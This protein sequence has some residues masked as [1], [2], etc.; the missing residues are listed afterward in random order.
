M[1]ISLVG[2]ARK[3][4][5]RP[6]Q[7]DGEARSAVPGLLGFLTSLNEPVFEFDET[8]QCHYM[9][10]AFR[11]LVGL[12]AD[13]SEDPQLTIRRDNV[14]PWWLRE[15]EYA[16]WNFFVEVHRSGRS[17]ELGIRPKVFSLKHVDGSDVPCELIG[18]RLLSRTG[19]LLGLV[20][21]VT[22]L[23]VPSNRNPD[24]SQVTSEL[25]RLSSAVKQLVAGGDTAVSVPPRPFPFVERRAPVVK[26]VPETGTRDLALVPDADSSTSSRLESLSDRE[27]DILRGLLEGKR[28]ATMARE[29]FLSEHTIR[30]H[31]K[32]IYRKVG[33]HSLGELREVVMPIADDLTKK[34]GKRK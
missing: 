23:T 24:L 29:L 30:N 7:G 10:P 6:G 1:A 15:D 33:V 26:A 18:E 14:F 28:T 16:R 17:V 21:I 3:E 22:P 12:A 27:R 13:S 31:L 32:H 2:G 19:V 25:H 8:G 20:G 9:N 34:S 11:A 5:P 4:P